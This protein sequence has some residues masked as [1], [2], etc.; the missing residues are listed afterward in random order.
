MS[1]RQGL[2]L[3]IRQLATMAIL[4]G[5]VTACATEPEAPPRLASSA[6]FCADKAAAECK[7]AVN[8]G[9]PVPA[10]VAQRT[11]VC[12]D[13][14]TASTAAGRKYTVALAQGCLDKTAALYAKITPLSPDDFAGVRESCERVLAGVIAANGA[15][16][17]S[18]Y[19]C[20]GKLVC[21]KGFC[22]ATVVK[23]ANEPCANPGDAC[24][25]GSYCAPLATGLSVCQAKKAKGAACSNSDKAVGPCAEDFRCV[26]DVLG[27]TCVDRIASGGACTPGE[28]Q[29]A[30]AAPYCDV[31]AKKCVAGAIF[32]PTATDLCKDYG[33]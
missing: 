1:N 8:C 22:A 15:C 17:K 24:A 23:K 10:C 6:N 31:T 26:T 5:M 32:G 2:A 33:G 25:K 9:N 16:T 13:F 14:V 30:V 11:K 20:T 21:D 27:S 3:A 18:D 29:C 28:D 4:A 7:A 19:D 12:A